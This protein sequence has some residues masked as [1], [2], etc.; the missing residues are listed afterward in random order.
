[1]RAQSKVQVAP[2]V[3]FVIGEPGESHRERSRDQGA[4]GL[5]GQA[6]GQSPPCILRQEL[7]GEL[8][9]S[10][11]TGMGGRSLHRRKE[12]FGVSLQRLQSPGGAGFNPSSEAEPAAAAVPA[13]TTPQD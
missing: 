11:P 1:M 3:V 8:R 7:R 13:Q 10:P 6:G 5:A 4:S 12:A 2:L 9:Q